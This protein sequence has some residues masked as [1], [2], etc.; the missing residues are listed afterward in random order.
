MTDELEQAR[1][2]ID[3]I[4]RDLGLDDPWIHPFP[5]DRRSQCREVDDRGDAS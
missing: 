4:D 2:K 5:V 3:E 1:E